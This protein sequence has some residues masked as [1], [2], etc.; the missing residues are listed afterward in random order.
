MLDKDINIES[1]TD[2][3]IY[4]KGTLLTNDIPKI[5]VRY[6]IS[7]EELLVAQ[8]ASKNGIG[9]EILMDNE[10]FRVEKWIDG[11]RITSPEIN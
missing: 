4:A 2:R 10:R 9:P 8:E 7:S 1:K 11:K 5:I 3:L 6:N